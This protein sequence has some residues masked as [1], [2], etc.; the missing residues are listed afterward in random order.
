[1]TTQRLKATGCGVAAIIVLLG[2]PPAFAQERTA[3]K[4][5]ERAV[6]I[7]VPYT[8]GGGS[9]VLMRPIAQRLN[10]R[11][12][13][14]VVVDNRGGAG[15]VLGTGIVAKAAPD[16]YTLLMIS[17]AHAINATLVKKLP[18]DPVADFVP[19]VL[20]MSAP[21][22]LVSHPSVPVR[23]LKELVALA[24]SRPGKL[25]YATSGVGTSIHLGME[26]F[27]KMAGVD[28]VAVHYKGAAPA[29]SDVI[30]GHVD[31][32]M[33]N[34]AATKPF[35]V[36]GKLNALGVSSVR[37][38]HLMPEVPTMAEQGLPGFDVSTWYG[39]VAPA[40]TPAEVIS[41]VNADVVATLS[42]EEFRQQIANSEGGEVIGNTAAEFRAFLAA[43]FTRW[44][45]LI[46]ESNIRAD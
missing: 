41:K 25:S 33:P 9:D 30:G 21:N 43:E 37:R 27:K 34:V 6:R 35:V 32:V 7:V 18:F 28:I 26:L 2:T 16:G 22:L 23:T 24:K 45:T 11:W 46:R 40:G 31:L 42:R 17:P 5:P 12:G 13:V 36:A 20:L 8:P 14:P 29:R 3:G 10:E 4:Y 15:S 44:G 38:S 39:L 1:M 19:I